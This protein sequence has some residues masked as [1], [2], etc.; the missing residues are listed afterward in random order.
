MNKD[1][2]KEKLASLHLDIRG[3]KDVLKKRLKSYFKRKYIDRPSTGGGRRQASYRYFV[4][5]DF[6][7]TCDEHSHHYPHEI[8]EFPAVLVNA[9]DGSVVDEFHSFVRPTVNPYLTDFCKT[10]TSITQEQV[11]SAEIF[12]EV[13]RR[14]ES[15]L[16]AH[17]LGKEN[18]F[19]IVT[20][21][22]WDMS[23]FLYMQCTTCDIPYPQW[24]RR[25][26]NIRKA[27]CN[28]YHVPK[29]SVSTMLNILG[30]AFE[31]HPH[32]G[33]DDARNIARILAQLITDE[34]NVYENEKLVLNPPIAAADAQ[35]AE[36]E[37]L[38][39]A[40]S[41]D[42]FDDA[43]DDS[44]MATDSILDKKSV[45]GNSIGELSTAQ[46]V[47]TNEGYDDPLK[48]AD[49]MERFSF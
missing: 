18:R 17:R 43:N 38:A 40:D 19:A 28:A 6:E 27:F 16:R 37:V 29:C 32:S 10:L 30:L 36:V 23:R 31:G 46:P 34:C 12:P 4:V 35:A 14:M 42:N 21:G 49:L 24:A 7:A 25:W 13:L 41:V 9:S 44:R 33:I 47:Y 5:I 11:N 8:I 3:Q 22:P 39:A 1:Q 20:D 15:W 2:M 48:C 26:V 45:N